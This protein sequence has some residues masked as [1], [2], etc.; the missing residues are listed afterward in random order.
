MSSNKDLE[1]NG[2]GVF[3]S[4]IRAPEDAAPDFAASE[5]NWRGQSVRRLVRSEHFSV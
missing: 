3:E 1:G 2:R 5:L 4:D